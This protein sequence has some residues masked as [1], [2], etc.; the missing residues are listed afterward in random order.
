[1]NWMERFRRTVSLRLWAHRSIR[2]LAYVR[3]SVVEETPE[4]CVVA[5]PLS[6]RTRNHLG[7][8]YFGALC[9]GADAAAALIA[10]NATRPDE[11]RFSILFKDV[12]GEFFKR[13][14][15]DVHF[16][17]EQGAQIRAVLEKARASGQRESVPLAVVA[18]VPALLG[19]EP[20]ARFELTL[21]VKRRERRE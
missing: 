19:A 3:P 7:S 8:M 15:G 20:V 12:R 14:E 1:M 5:I 16:A 9:T 13:A 10:L 4:R 21:S 17:C 6:G 11:G 18:T 2:L